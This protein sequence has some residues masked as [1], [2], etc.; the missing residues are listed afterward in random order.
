[1]VR[2]MVINAAEKK[3]GWVVLGRWGGEGVWF[4]TGC[5]G[6]VC[7]AQKVGKTLLNH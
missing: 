4:Y 2:E 3:L 5:E 6:V 1:M 7:A